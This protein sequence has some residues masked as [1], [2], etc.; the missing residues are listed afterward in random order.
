MPKA[1]KKGA[2]CHFKIRF[3]VEELNMLTDTLAAN[4]EVVFMQDNRRAA[5]MRKK[6]IWEE[7]AHK[8]SA[9]GTTPRTIKD[10]RK[11]WDD[12]RLRVRS[13]LA[14]NRSQGIGTGGGGGSPIKMTHWEE[15][16][17]S[18]IGIE[19]IEGVEEMER[20]VPSSADGGSQS[21]SE[22]QDSAA[23]ATTPMKKARGM[24]GGNRPSTSRGTG[25]PGLLQK[26]KAIQDDTSTRRERGTDNATA[27]TPAAPNTQEPVAE[28]S[29]S[30][31]NSSVGEV[32]ATAPLSDEER[33]CQTPVGQ[34]TPS[35]AAVKPPQPTPHIQCQQP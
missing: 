34:G 13:I 27:P 15:T 11:R 10:V 17:A 31:A 5:Q 1:L 29:L 23:Q 16:C 18:T 32:A 30:A 21:D 26:A 2:A 9:V 33:P 20:G 8:V 28:G 7:V 25:K 22:D 3:S 19:T 35:P 12:L 24:E 4:V 6:E 14:A